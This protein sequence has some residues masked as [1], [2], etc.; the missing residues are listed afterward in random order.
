AH[1]S[2][3]SITGRWFPTD[4]QN[5]RIS[6]NRRR[7]A[8]IGFPD[9]SPPIFFQVIN[10]PFTNLDKAS[11]RYEWRAV[12]SWLTRLSAGGY[13]Q[14]QDR[15]LRNN[16]TV[17]GSTPPGPGDPPV[18]TVTMVHILS[19]TRQTVKSHGWDFQAN[20]QIGARNL[21]TTGASSF[22][23]HSRDTRTAV[24]DVT[25]L[26]ILTRPPSP[27]RFFPVYEEIVKG[28]V[29]QPQRV[30]ISDFTNIAWFIQD[31]FRAMR[32][33]RL[34]G[35][36][37]VDHFNVST[38]PT[39]GYDP[40]LPGIDRA[41]PPIDPKNFPAAEGTT[42]TRTTSTGDFGIVVQPN[43]S[44]S[45]SARIGRSFRHPN[46]E[47]LFFTGPATIGNIVANINVKP[48]TGVN[49]DVSAKVRTGRYAGGITYFNNTYTNFIST[50]IISNSSTAGL[51]SQ[52]INFAKIRIQGI[53][54]DLQVPVPYR[55]N[56]FTFYGN[57]GYQHGQILAG[58]N[59]YNHVSVSDTPADNI[60]PFKSVVG[61]RWNDAA[62]RFWSEYSARITT[63]VNRVSPLLIDSP[64]LI[65]QDL[66]SLYGFT[67]HTLRA[68]YNFRSER[69]LV[70]ITVAIENL[71]NKYYRD[72][73]QFAPSRGRSFTLGLNFRLL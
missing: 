65:A 43:G 32:W 48:E 45:F 18:D 67:L 71:G 63:H 27:V 50:E 26:G 25:K 41:V 64:F 17:F 11:A 8:S 49:V 19:N 55:N 57:L 69:S 31:E 53:E 59:P 28:F 29:S 47:E 62:D 2:D 73:F 36:Y 21:V 13:W 56:L 37:R 12:T 23:D 42:I 24:T 6:L 30:P 4:N 10:T 52:A 33:L 60:T 58:E 61:L 68:G 38:L 46:L 70:G 9:F 66:F 35:S 5:I 54:A 51:I 14:G 1:G 39:P 16:F 15:Q 44:L 34:I 7:A 22:R 72:Q 20:L 40:R 3:V